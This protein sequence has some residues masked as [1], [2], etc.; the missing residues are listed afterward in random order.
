[1]LKALERVWQRT[2]DGR[3]FTCIQKDVDQFVQKDGSIRTYKADEYQL[4]NITTGH[5]LLLLSQLSVPGNDKYIKAAQLLHKQLETQPPHQR[6]RLLA[7]ENLPQPDV[8]RRPVH[9]RAVLRRVQP[10]FQ[11]AGRP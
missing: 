11:P 4:D 10:D 3:Y 6:R 8:A 7:Q 9:G 5:A 1:M 2:G